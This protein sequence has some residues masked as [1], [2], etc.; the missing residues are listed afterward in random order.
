MSGCINTKLPLWRGI[1]KDYELSKFDLH[2]IFKPEEVN[3]MTDEQILE[4]ISEFGKFN[5]FIKGVKEFKDIRSIYDNMKGDKPGLLEREYSDETYEELSEIFGEG[6]LIK[7]KE[8]N[9]IIVRKPMLSHRANSMEP[10]ERAMAGIKLIQHN[11]KIIKS[12]RRGKEGIKAVNTVTGLANK[13]NR[14]DS[15]QKS[16]AFS[17][18]TPVQAAV[19]SILG[20]EVDL[21]LKAE[22]E[23]GI[24]CRT[25]THLEFSDDD[26]R[27]A[28]H[29]HAMHLK[30][31]FD[32]EIPGWKAITSNLAIRVDQRVKDPKTGE[33][34]VKSHDGEPDV[35][36]VDTNGN[37]Y[38][39]DIKTKR[40]F[41]GELSTESYSN[42]VSQSLAYRRQ[43]ESYVGM[44]QAQYGDYFTSVK[45]LGLY[46]LPTSYNTPEIKEDKE[47]ENP[48]SWGVAASGKSEVTDK[49]LLQSK[50]NPRI[51]VVLQED[52]IIPSD[53][54]TEGEKEDLVFSP[55]YTP[56]LMYSV[57]G[58]MLKQASISRPTRNI[59]TP[60]IMKDSFYYNPSIS[61]EEK[62]VMANTVM[63][64]AS[65]VITELQNDPNAAEELD[66]TLLIGKDTT[67]M[68]REEIIK[69]AGGIKQILETVRDQ[70][71][72]VT[73]QYYIQEDINSGKFNEQDVLSMEAA[74]EKMKLIDA[75]WESFCRIG[76]A[77]MIAL[78][79]V[80]IVDNAN[81]NSIHTEELSFED[82]MLIETLE[83]KH[84]ETWQQGVRNISA[85]G[86]LSTRIR[87]LLARLPQVNEKGEPISDPYGY[88][89]Y[90]YLDDNLAVNSMLDWLKYCNT[91]EEMI[92]VLEEKA[93]VH[94][95]VNKVLELIGHEATN[96][97]EYDVI[98]SQFFQNFRKDFTSYSAIHF[99]ANKDGSIT[100][101]VKILNT[102][103][104]DKFLISSAKAAMMNNKLE[105]FKY[106]SGSLSLSGVVSAEGVH[107][108]DTAIASLKTKFNTLQ[109]K[110]SDTSS[111]EYLQA[112]ELFSESLLDVLH[113]LGFDVDNSTPKSMV[114][115]LINNPND[116]TISSIIETVGHI[117][118]NFNNAS[119]EPTAFSPF[120]EDDKNRV[121]S[122]YKELAELIAPHIPDS[123]ES[124]IYENGKMYYSFIAPSN[125]GKVINRLG[126]KGA[127]S[128]A[129]YMKALE[130]EYLFSE[131]FM[132]NGEIISPWLNLLQKNAG[133]RNLLDHKVQLHSNHVG[134]TDMG[135]IAYAQSLLLEYFYEKDRTKNNLTAW[136]RVP[137][138]SNKPSSEFIKFLRFAGAGYQTTIANHL[139]S[140]L[141]QETLRIRTVLDNAKSN[142]KASKT[143]HFDLVNVK[144]SIQEK[145]DADKALTAADFADLTENGKNYGAEFK[146]LEFLNKELRDENSE[147]GK[148]LRDKINNRESDLTTEASLKKQFTTALN[149]FM[150]S[151]V[152]SEYEYLESIGL[153]EIEEDNFD[154]KYTY[155]DSI[156][157]GN[158][159]GYLETIHKEAK[160]EGK[161]WYS[162]LG[163]II[164][165]AK[166][167]G[168]DGKVNISTLKSD[169][170]KIK[171][172]T[173]K[174]E[175]INLIKE[176]MQKD[177]KSSIAEYVWNDSF[178]SLNIIQLTVGDLAFFKNTED[179]QKRFAQVHSP[180]LKLNTAAVFK[181]EKGAVRRYS[182]DGINRTLYLKDEDFSSTVIPAITSVFDKKISSTRNPAEKA[183]WTQI[184]SDVIKD[185]KSINSTD[186]QA[187][188]A[189]TATRKKLAMAG[190]WTPALEEAYKRILSGNYSLSDVQA[191]MQPSK[192]FN[193]TYEKVSTGSNSISTLKRTVQHKN[194]EYTLIIADALLRNE[195]DSTL[196]AIFDIMEESA[197][198]N[199]AY[200]G[201]GID[202]IMFGSCVKVG[203]SEEV[204][205]T[206]K[207]PDEIR[208]ILRGHI[209]KNG[210]K[211]NGYNL[212]YIHETPFEDYLIQ[213]EVPAH[214]M[215]H[216]QL[217]GS[218]FRVLSLSDMDNNAP[219]S[220]YNEETGKFEEKDGSTVK[221]EAKN[222]IADNIKESYDQLVEDFG[223]DSAD[224]KYRNKR[225]SKLLQDAILKDARYGHDLYL[226]VGLN[227]EG[228]FN[229]P[230][231]DPI[232]S[233]RIQQLLNSIV[234]SRIN[235]QKVTGGPIVQTTG[236][237][238]SEDLSMRWVDKEGNL[239]ESFSE[240][241]EKHK[242]ATADDYKAYLK[243]K[244]AKFAYFECYLPI[245][246][247]E[248]KDALTKPNGELMSVEEAKA[249]GILNDESLKAIGYRIPTEDKYSMMPMK[250]KGF[251][252]GTGGEAIMLPKEITALTGA[253]FDID[254]MYTIIKTYEYDVKE[255]GGETTVNRHV[256]NTI[257]ED[258]L[259]EDFL[260]R[261]GIDIE[262]AKYAKGAIKS[263]NYANT[264]KFSALV[265]QRLQLPESDSNFL[266]KDYAEKEGDLYEKIKT[267]ESLVNAFINE[268]RSELIKAK[269]TTKITKTITT[270]D[271]RR[272]EDINNNKLFNLQWAI[273]TNDDT[274]TKLFRPQSFEEQRHTAKIVNAAKAS[275]GDKNATYAS[276]SKLKNEELDKK[277][278]DKTNRSILFTST[279]VMYHNQNMVAGSLI[280]IF[281][282]NNVSHAFVQEQDIKLQFRGD[283]GGFTFDGIKVTNEENNSISE[284]KDRNGDLISRRIASFLG[285]SVDAV[286]D[287][288][289][290][291]LNLNTATA[292]VAML[293]TRLGFDSDAIGLF[294]T[295]P[296]I[297]E[298]CAEYFKRSN[299]GYVSM[300]EVIESM[301]AKLDYAGVDSLKDI[302]LTE[303]ENL[304]TKDAMFKSITMGATDEYKAATLALFKTLHAYSQHLG[305]LTF[306]TKFNSV[307]NAVGP[308]IADT[309]IKEQRVKKF[310]DAIAD[311]ETSPFSK[312]AKNIIE[313][314]PILNAF[315]KYTMGENGA[316]SRLFSPYFP[317]YSSR[318]KSIID[319]IVADTKSPLDAK[320]INIIIGDFM[321]YCLTDNSKGTPVIDGSEQ[322]REYYMYNFPGVFN[323]DLKLYHTLPVF[324]STL[325][326]EATTKVPIPTIQTVVGG[327][328]SSQ[329]ETAKA[330]WADA[331]MSDNPTIQQMAYEKAIYM[332]MK[333]GFNFSPR[334]DM[335]LLGT[336]A[337][338][339]LG[340]Y[341]EAL[342]DIETMTSSSWD[343][344][345]F[346]NQ[347][348][349]NRHNIYKLVPNV[350]FSP[351]TK[352][353]VVDGTLSLSGN[354]LE[355]SPV[356]IRKDSAGNPIYI[357]YI[358]YKNRLYIQKNNSS[359]LL[360]TDSYKVEYKEI[361]TLGVTNN[362]LE[363][364]M[365]EGANIKTVF[366]KEKTTATA[367]SEED[368]FM[369]DEPYFEQHNSET[370]ETS[371]HQ[372]EPIVDVDAVLEQQFENP[373][374]VEALKAR[375]AEEEAAE[376]QSSSDPIVQ[377]IE[378]LANSAKE[379]TN[380]SE[381]I[382]LFDK[383]V[384]YNQMNTGKVAYVSG[385][386]TKTVHVTPLSVRNMQLRD[387]AI[388]DNTR[389]RKLLAILRGAGF[390]VSVGD[391]LT[392]GA[393][394]V[395]DP[396][397][398]KDSSDKL[399][400]VLRFA[401]EQAFE[402][403]FPEE[404]AHFAIE[405]LKHT[406]L[407][408]RILEAI[409][410]NGLAE[411]ILGEEY[412][413]YK[414]LYKEDKQLLAKEAAGK[415]LAAKI[416]GS[417]TILNNLYSRAMKLVMDL[418]G[419]I[420]INEV[421]TLIS[422]IGALSSVVQ[423]P[424]VINLIDPEAIKS[425]QGKL[426]QLDKKVQQ[427]KNLADRGMKA[428]A[429]RMRVELVRKKGGFAQGY[430]KKDAK[431]FKKIVSA[432]D[433]FESKGNV[434]SL[435]NSITYFITDAIDVMKDLDSKIKDI[436][437]EDL[438]DSTNY[439]EINKC[440]QL[441]NRIKEFDSGYR[442]VLV[443]LKTLGTAL[444]NFQL[445]DQEDTM[446]S[447][448]QK[449]AGEV[450]QLLDELNKMYKDTR[451]NA[452]YAFLRKYWGEDKKIITV[453]RHRGESLSLYNLLEEG[454]KD[455]GIFDA[456]ISSMSD[457]NDPLLSTIDKAVKLAQMNRNRV[458]QELIPTIRQA[459]LDLIAAGE[460]SDFILERDENGIPTGR[461]ISNIDYAKYY[462][463]RQAKKESLK[464]QGLSGF[465]LYEA[466]QAWESE[467]CEQVLVDPTY[468][469]E[470][471]Y[472]I[473]PK[474]EL[475]KSNAL[476]GLNETQRKYYEFI[477]SAK[478][479]IDS[480]IPH[481]YVSQHKA[482]QMRSDITEALLE[483]KMST[484]QGFSQ[485]FKIF[486]EKFSITEDDA[487][488]FG[489]DIAEQ[490]E[491][492]GED[493]IA[494]ILG[495][496]EED[497]QQE[498]EEA[499]KEESTSKKI[500]HKFINLD[501]SGKR[502]LR[503]LPVFYTRM[504]K[505]KSRLTTDITGSL[506][507]YTG[508][509]V[510]YSE[511][512]KIVDCLELVKD[513]ISER[514][515]RQLSGDQQLV[516][517]YKVM[518]KVFSDNYTAK[519][520]RIEERL[521][522]YF[523]S[524]VY[525]QHKKDEMWFRLFGKKFS[526]AKGLDAF[527]EYSGNL[528]LAFNGFSALSNV[529]IGKTQLLLE[530]LGRNN[531]TYADMAKAKVE[532][533]H[534]VG[535]Y[536]LQH[537]AV[538]PDNRLKLLMDR[539]NVTDDFFEDLRH[540]KVYNSA[541]VRLL[542]NSSAMFLNS[543]GEHYLRNRT[544]LAMLMHQKVENAEGQEKSLYDI[545]KE[546]DIYSDKAQTQKVGKKIVVEEGYFI[547]KDDQK[548][549]VND[550]FLD[551]LALKISKV[552]G[553][554]NGQFGETDKGAIHRYAI[555]RLAMQFRQWMPGHYYRRFAGT[556]YD[557]ASDEFREGFYTTLGRLSLDL[558]RD[559][560]NFKKAAIFNWGTL[561]EYERA[562]MRKACAEIT[563]FAL[564]SLLCC[565]G[566]VGDWKKGVWAERMLAYTLLR[567]R[568]EV[569][570]SSIE[571][572]SFAKNTVSLLNSP[573]A[574]INA[575]ETVGNVLQ[576]WNMF[577]TI[578]SGRWEGWSKWS[579]DLIEAM[580]GV[581][582]TIKLVDIASPD[583]R[584]M[585]T[586]YE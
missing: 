6:N 124:S 71:F 176:E 529:T 431:A 55:H 448:I 441:L 285:A 555:G 298:L 9:T 223:L 355:L 561:S 340:G 126:N 376:K 36:I 579:R 319:T 300:G 358:K 427:L 469:E 117:K 78:E 552:N 203:R 433:R 40:D 251:L 428:K 8:S 58:S 70:F 220:V 247:S 189:P 468:G 65:S 314:D 222:L 327:Y 94:P 584:H 519:G 102:V 110:L 398:S 259:T 269:K 72:G 365:Y 253:D 235:K 401:D 548:I 157:T 569:G 104:K 216:K 547:K 368:D 363:Y 137:I 27:E 201:K 142:S 161:F 30:A 99:M 429:R 83:E 140:V 34:T 268:Y 562:N 4:K 107:K 194:S 350:R 521:Q 282:N 393:R 506:I 566:P 378:E 364:N 520:R 26:M 152:E 524:V 275:K 331:L 296:I 10:K 525:G 35:L 236:Y 202:A 483:N 260:T 534:L 317:H 513:Q 279:Q 531:F 509:A 150:K 41:N 192:P 318:V 466:M 370:L 138:L 374:G 162:E 573:A 178:A 535:S 159:V 488:D 231:S 313:N 50:T 335:H 381:I 351:T 518:K 96:I 144:K 326:S 578:E 44:L 49:K 407:V 173:A 384:K 369:E 499:T 402:E 277:I 273:L 172:T 477:M 536:F 399:L 394:A 238:L 129:D 307:S 438:K 73:G 262:V 79:G 54:L 545:L 489:E 471:R 306:M 89:T 411:V 67:K 109:R 474:Q 390:D 537:N 2:L 221:K 274:L 516:E 112:V 154:I 541:T 496:E 191:M 379:I 244:A 432:I 153:M 347:L 329:Q 240:Y 123:I 462:A 443:D 312:E 133:N 93:E 302:K 478:A 272:K 31:H 165:K 111:P 141:Y 453:G 237:G 281:A 295:Q 385:G 115:A 406:G 105:M 134:Y 230:L 439:L 11:S 305:D 19:S 289:L 218:Q 103:A 344:A 475:Y 197:Y 528:G 503:K 146:F 87:R 166:R 90:L 204:D 500:A 493:L 400:K 186:G 323:E 387:K 167:A 206:G 533:Y 501:A 265:V 88:S 98:R 419:N 198:S 311:P 256:I 522:N 563:I 286:K 42:P 135:K 214:F 215:D 308:T 554:L 315:Y 310:K 195:E 586:M 341:I 95:W 257:V 454:S 196:K 241:K 546:Q 470:G 505:D 414:S 357:N 559:Y 372:D 163:E 145:I 3:E 491:S 179:F 395:F 228:E 457:V 502:R 426:Y 346:I 57:T 324:A 156:L 213:Q 334:G 149:T 85:N 303:T 556:Y 292:N 542:G 383:I 362:M 410:K 69:E 38:V 416:E 288:I 514:N 332:M 423:N 122:R 492:E 25:L 560:K 217:L 396:Q 143:E 449:R 232:Q 284:V 147:L 63:C 278:G 575:F 540:N 481:R 47:V 205:I 582:K 48:S 464:E 271:P 81:K 482:V 130:N 170:K 507:A 338:Q 309:I 367:L 76:Y 212:K 461:Y 572:I 527:R 456:W 266:T 39:L 108:L 450:V 224:A 530:S 415:L 349:R 267:V 425:F 37:L 446:I 22:L 59:S 193:A 523:D 498:S 543:A 504:L 245:P 60:S 345:A 119:I 32:K 294:L 171:S 177:L 148:L 45:S 86:S 209:Y 264:S 373:W 290:N 571:P 565:A 208:D 304:F 455:L 160:E 299:D 199:D 106:I 190:K 343:V 494:E 348:M 84:W 570:A 283:N 43:V 352:V 325:V 234:K 328:N 322:S 515:V 316:A 261:N 121:T 293:L 113:R 360:G 5:Y 405:G 397:S 544:M 28:V 472:E 116:S 97:E 480:L 151:Q 451:L 180:G 495:I 359:S 46:V 239:I 386:S 380:P 17:R 557:A 255:R 511:F 539:F 114:V 91:L 564:L 118:Y 452:S 485:V 339:A 580:P 413:N 434:S 226:A 248:L 297:E 576:F 437:I 80:S 68:T 16:D 551:S 53:T 139:Y 574:A 553:S 412:E 444:R 330:S 442:D 460:N 418:Y 445:T 371:E 436:N 120:N 375:I 33:Y 1:M 430:D 320:T 74:L 100:P 182:E 558:I 128:N 388:A 333:N 155:L 7:N 463:D 168:K 484:K 473:R 164:N 408:N 187:Y 403:A 517:T 64:E 458:L 252:P 229:I 181:D 82:D 321:Y 188:S 512:S 287:P 225:I 227:E 354:S 127:L 435:F 246:D 550:D 52:P 185:L 210:N 301:F 62:R 219:F 404:Y 243:S 174:N 490:E 510:N 92:K 549:A 24:D 424:Q 23:E 276:Y 21:M 20:N 391:E 56:E 585:F 183:V 487:A 336:A 447:N 75:N 15:K 101:T 568:M 409:E 77:K 337:K 211:D 280:G 61:M 132:A 200:N 131:F 207:T 417:D 66:L 361:S 258:N 392:E 250:V 169:L 567:M 467:N 125:L 526:T 353:T 175:I 577:N 476:N 581:D 136:Y 440:C 18:N 13:Q 479:Q 422:D 465:K 270:K 356:I 389:H 242:D 291:Y 497:K 508:M 486:K 14:E 382:Q 158:L 538:N 29:S 420:N 12:I 233:I 377:E 51:E 532:Y 421:E 263:G 342:R 184:K 254:K 366:S 459:H 249:K 583:G